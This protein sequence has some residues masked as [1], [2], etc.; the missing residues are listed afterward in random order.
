M[1]IQNNIPAINT[2]RQYGINNANV[3]KSVEKL[4]SGYR[5]NRAGDDAAGLAISEKMR[6]Q[7]RGL[8]MASKNSQDAVSLIQTAEGALQSTHNVLQRM[9]E[10]AVQSAS[11]T[12]EQ[13]VDR[14]ALQAEFAQLKA[15]IDDTATKTRFND[16]NLIDGTFQ[17]YTSF[18]DGATTTLNLSSLHQLSVE[19][20]TVGEYN[21][22]TAVVTAVA[23]K[24]VS[25]N[26][27]QAKVYLSTSTT[28]ALAGAAGNATEIG[29]GAAAAG[30]F[31]GVSLS[32]LNTDAHNGN[33]YTLK[34]TGSDLESMTFQLTDTNGK[35]V[36]TTVVNIEKEWTTGATTAA[37]VAGKVTFKGVGTFN[38]QGAVSVDANGASAAVN[39]SLTNYTQLSGLN[40]LTVS[41]GTGV[42]DVSTNAVAQK[43]EV[44]I[45]GI[46][47]QV[48]KGD[49]KIDFKELGITF[50]LKSAL[51]DA[52]VATT[53]AFKDATGIEG[54]AAANVGTASAIQITVAQTVNN[55]II[56]QSGANQGDELRITI[57]AMN[58]GKLGV[59]FSDISTQVNASNAITEVN[60][61]I[62]QVSTQRAALG[63]LQNRLDYKIANLDTSAENLQAAESRIRDV[64]MAKEMTNF[65]KNNILAQAATAM[66]AQANSLPQGVLQLLG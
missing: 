52:A 35:A 16:Q 5:V 28:S 62:N 56:I 40:G 42:S 2:H 13:T 1:R 15:E 9:R 60:D 18:R 14:A 54:T 32:G 45:N 43:M 59:A 12:N 3:A 61:A 25:G 19:R 7:I 11:D 10:L 55:G 29:T 23:A 53:N 65:M 47:K 44:T 30:I 8:N 24:T 46:T 66:L 38:F 20:A 64:D 17:K 36:A 50:K 48:V 37:G 26:A 58:T 31:T 22:K 49:D 6:A 51:T 34:V 63:A 27:V 4:S 57:D 21:I 41:L 39:N 33:I